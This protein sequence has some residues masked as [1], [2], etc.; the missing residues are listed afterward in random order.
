VFLMKGTT[1]AAVALAFYIAFGVL[2]L[3]CRC[4]LQWSR[5]G[6]T[7][8]RGISRRL[9]LL[10]LVGGVGFVVAM[11]GGLIAPLLQLLG[12]VSPVRSLDNQWDKAAGIALAVCGLAATLYAQLDMGDS[13]RVGVDTREK[14]TL[15]RTGAFRLIRNPIFAA[16]LVFTL[17][18]T[19]LAPNLIG[20]AV[21]VIFLL[22]I[23]ISVRTV[24]EPHLRETHGDAYRDY[25][26]N[27]GRFVP[28]IGRRRSS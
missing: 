14:T 22:A 2:A 17:G 21:F 6:S 11:V 5:T 19:L 25:T 13:W 28:G 16:M 26:A 18:E 4:W 20:I 1:M 23:E 24:E 27:V 12:V 8:Y 9:G 10:G 15:V 3:V 7:G